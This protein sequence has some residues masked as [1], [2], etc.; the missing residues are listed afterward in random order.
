MAGIPDKPERMEIRRK[1][2]NRAEPEAFAH[3][4]G[5][6][7]LVAHACFDCR[8]SWKLGETSAAICPECRAPLHWMGRAFRVPKKN[9]EEQ[10]ARVRALWLAGFRFLGDTGRREAEPYP[11]RLHDVDDF[12]RRNATHPFRVA[13]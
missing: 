1:I 10:W 4:R 9:D 5:P 12:V 7:Y 6:E 2:G 3:H 13:G 8:K 11:E